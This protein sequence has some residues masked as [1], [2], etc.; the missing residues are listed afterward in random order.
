[1]EQCHPRLMLMIDNLQ[2]MNK[3][4]DDKDF[5]KCYQFATGS[6]QFLAIYIRPDIA[7]AAGWLAC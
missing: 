2:I 7:F 6:L 1:M 3:S 5:I 4:V